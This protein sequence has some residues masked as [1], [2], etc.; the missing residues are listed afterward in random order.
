MIVKIPSRFLAILRIKKPLERKGT[1][2]LAVFILGVWLSG[3]VFTESMHEFWRDEVRPLSLARAAATPA[4]LYNSVQYDGH[5]MLW[6]FLLY[7]GKSIVD[8]P[9]ILP[10]FAVGIGFVAV[11]VF[12]L[13][14]PMPLW[15]KSL[16]IFSAFPF[17]EYSVM[18]RNYGITMLMLFLIAWV[19][20]H[21]E[22]WGLLLAFLVALL[23]NTNAHSI[24]FAGL[25]TA[26]WM[27]DAIVERRAELSRRKILSLGLSAI[28]ITAGAG[29]SILCFMP[30]ENTILTS[31]HNILTWP[32]FLEALKESAL[33]PEISFYQIMPAWVPPAVVALII[34]LAI[35]GLMHRPS[36]LVA[37]FLGEIGLGIL[38]HLVY[39]GQY[40]HQGLFLIFTITLYWLLLEMQGNENISGIRKH[41]FRIGFFIA[42]PLIVLAGVSQMRGTAWRDIRM[43]Q[44][45]SKA[46]GDFLNSDPSY[47]N[48]ILLPEPDYSIEAVAYYAENE[49][50]LPREQRFGNTVAWTKDSKTDLSLSELM[51]AARDLQNRCGKPVLIILGHFGVEFSQPGE[52]RYSYNK[53]FTWDTGSGADFRNSTLFLAEFKQSLDEDEKYQ[54]YALLE[55]PVQSVENSKGL[56]FD[57]TKNLGCAQREDSAAFGQTA[58]I[59]ASA[60]FIG[61]TA[62][63]LNA[64]FRGLQFSTAWIAR[65][66]DRLIGYPPFLTIWN[67]P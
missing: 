65:I 63:R 61:N 22:K 37:A 26:I 1:A 14:A 41:L 10:I 18:A 7:A 28:L 40:R 54:V 36:L 15:L 27:W 45:S 57:F 56:P 5:P 17:Y 21:R 48:A 29:F 8:S 51:A 6:H 43:E 42:I 23:A 25:L 16:F 3:V 20:P 50:Y 2:V 59:A 64:L 9:L 19:Y 62:G 24:I 44:S 11:A 4:D 53:L 34:F 66:N 55:K 52:R 38:F 67:Y 30:R 47:R 12:L 32:N 49:I 35:L 13:F 33:H 60:A 58:E 39:V 46:L 31:V